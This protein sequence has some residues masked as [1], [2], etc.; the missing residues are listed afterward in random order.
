[1]K[2][3][4]VCL[5]SDQEKF[6]SLFYAVINKLQQNPNKCIIR[7]IV[8][9]DRRQKKDNNQNQD[10]ALAVLVKQVLT[11]KQKTDGFV[12]GIDLAGD[13][14]HGEPEDFVAD[15]Q[16]AFEACFPVTIHAGEEQ[17]ADNI[18]K[19]AYYLH[20]D[21]IGHGLTLIDSDD[22]QDKFRNRGICLEMC[23]SSNC[24][25]VGFGR[26]DDDKYPLL[27]LWRKG[28]PVAICTDNP[29]FSETTLSKEY[30]KAGELCPELTLW[31]ALA[32]MKQTFSN[33]FLPAREKEVMLKQVDLQIFQ[34]I[35]AWKK[36][37]R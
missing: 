3:T 33:A 25:V 34:K 29:A 15:F 12:V 1:M 4:H 13:E 28:I 17:N 27:E 11:M 22:L 26:P 23:P 32:I 21:R 35:I 30:A 20:A 36:I 16:P 14:K 31:E 6:I 5:V 2:C 10:D 24:E 8:I 18:W 9:V 37:K 19:A 7:F